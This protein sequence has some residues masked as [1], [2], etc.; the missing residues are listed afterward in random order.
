M[1][2]LRKRYSVA[3]YLSGLVV[4]ILWAFSLVWLTRE[5]RSDPSTSIRRVSYSSL[6][7]EFQG[8]LMYDIHYSDRSIGSLTYRI[9]PEL[10]GKALS[11]TLTIV[12]PHSG[13][14]PAISAKGFAM[15]DS[16]E[17][18]SSFGAELSMANRAFSIK[19]RNRD[20][21][22]GLFI[23][24]SGMGHSSSRV[25]PDHSDIVVGDG[26][27]P[28]FPCTCPEPGER[29]TWQ[30]LDPLSLHPV[31]VALEEEKDEVSPP[32]PEG[33]CVLAMKIQGL[34]SLIWIDSSGLVLREKTPMGWELVLRK[35]DSINTSIESLE[36][37]EA[38]HQ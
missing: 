24:Y 22:S 36:V 11:W 37:S 25:I 38:E 10:T 35:I 20:D 28:G 8:E 15:F 14:I 33:G 3:F 2:V 17:T 34:K 31:D 18:L 9:L 7:P 16:S 27:F 4:L 6:L 29:L 13:R 21:D 19:G 26:F 30:L 32:P 12:A 5:T 1:M 23:E